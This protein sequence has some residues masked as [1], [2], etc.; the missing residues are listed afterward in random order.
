MKRLL[1]I[2]LLFVAAPLLAGDSE[3]PTPAPPAP[4]GALRGVGGPTQLFQVVLVRGAI[5]GSEEIVGIPKNAEKAIR[6]VRDFLPFK[7]YK[8]LDTGLLRLDAGGFGKVRLDGIPPQ[9]YDVGVAWRT[10]SSQKKILIWA[11]SVYAVRVPGATPLPRGVA[12]EAERPIIDTSFNLD[13]GETIVVGSSK[14]GGDQALIVLFTALP[15]R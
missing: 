8:V 4:N 7:S 12:P 1:A 15:N 11:F 5:N 3:Q 9:Q 14:L 10:A 2:A 13:V 6:D